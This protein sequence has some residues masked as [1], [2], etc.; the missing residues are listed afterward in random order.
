MTADQHD[1]P[2]GRRR[3]VQGLLGA[4]V[5]LGTGAGSAAAAPASVP[6]A[7]P[8]SVPD[9][10]GGSV[11]VPDVAPLPAAADDPPR[12][13][14]DP[15][16][17][18]TPASWTTVGL[19]VPFDAWVGRR[20]CI[21]HRG[22]GDAMPENSIE[23][24]SAALAWGA[25][26]MEVSVRSTSDGLLVVLHDSTLDRTTTGSG[27][28]AGR[29]AAYVGGL[30]LKAPQLG[31]GWS[32]PAVRV[33]TFEQVLQVCGGRTVLA[34]EAKDDSAYAAILA[35]VRRYGL[36][37]SVMIKVHHSNA[38]R[39][40]AAQRD[41]FAVFGYF[42]TASEISSTTIATLAGRLRHG[43]DYMILWG[44]S[45]DTGHGMLADS[46]VTT[47]VRTGHQIWV[48][49]VQRRHEADHFRAL[50]VSG[51]VTSNFGY[52]AGTL[53]P[54]TRDFWSRKKL[55]PGELT[56]APE[57]S[58]A[59]PTWTG[60]DELTLGGAQGRQQFLMLGNCSPVPAAR[61]TYTV[62]I[63]T[64]WTTLP[65]DR[66]GHI[67]IAFGEADDRYYELQNGESNG[68]H[69]VFRADGRLQ[70]Y[71]HLA[72]QTNGELLATATG[73]AHTSGRW[74]HLRLT[75]TPTT[76]T[77]SRTDTGVPSPVTARATDG[78]FR[79]GYLHIGRATAT[80]VVSFRKLAI[81]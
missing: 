45:S 74:M 46:L 71:A 58:T 7:A 59:G 65:S 60:P 40:S 78:R 2:I 61:G 52:V 14:P 30:A 67:D 22:S 50:G 49:P 33:P 25:T 34:V 77:L 16:G 17:A 72:G 56:I 43:R 6:G 29:T 68:Y 24:F 32:S 44:Y 4:G 62:D 81:S 19:P 36:A 80:G 31:P 38:A 57:S 69:A 5:L 73:P 15:G 63:D 26:C 28:V 18:Q 27:A 1:R 21:A 79:G 70:I 13:V 51:I 48:A 53:V 9:A 23:A 54:A 47:A 37:G 55:N 8:A 64:R 11:L 66:A 42:G 75:V 12:P 76:I 3:A 10:V 39:I 35:M 41:G 20:T